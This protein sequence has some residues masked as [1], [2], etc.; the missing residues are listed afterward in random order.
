MTQLPHNSE[1]LDDRKKYRRSNDVCWSENDKKWANSP[2]K[3]ILIK[4]IDNV[5]HTRIRGMI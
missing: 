2:K 3:A 1:G 4:F 5:I